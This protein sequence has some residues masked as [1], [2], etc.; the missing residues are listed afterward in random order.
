MRYRR[1]L[2]NANSFLIMKILTAIALLVVLVCY[3]ETQAVSSDVGV[4]P[5]A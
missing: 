3:L 1:L 5:I 2:P 4:G